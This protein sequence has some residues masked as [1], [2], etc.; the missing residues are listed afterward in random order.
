[1]TNH[2]A[3]MIKD[4]RRE[5]DGTWSVRVWEGFGTLAN[6]F[7]NARRYGGYRTRDEAR[8]A[9]ISTLPDGGYIVPSRNA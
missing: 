2:P 5:R 3:K 7:R 6:P 9:D 8:R 1:M 4:I